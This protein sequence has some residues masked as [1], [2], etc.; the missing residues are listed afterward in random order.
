MLRP[1]FGISSNSEMDSLLGQLPRILYFLMFS[2]TS[3]H[4][5]FGIV[6]T[7]SI[8]S[9]YTGLLTETSGTQMAHNRCAHLASVVCL[10]APAS[11]GQK[12]QSYATSPAKFSSTCRQSKHKRNPTHHGI[13]WLHCT[14]S[15]KPL[16][17]WDVGYT[18]TVYRASGD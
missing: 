17:F 11:A 18:I 1:C 15:A 4:L 10:K 3:F 7:P 14:F 12:M 6:A 16:T 9:M 2:P 8:G 5:L 13:F